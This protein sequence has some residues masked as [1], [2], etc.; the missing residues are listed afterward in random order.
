MLILRILP[1]LEKFSLGE[2]ILPVDLA[3]YLR[4]PTVSQFYIF[5][6]FMERRG[7]TY[8]PVKQLDLVVYLSNP[9]MLRH[10]QNALSWAHLVRL[11]LLLAEGP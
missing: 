1:L 8:T 9:P 5:A 3:P 2:I 4:G 7:K 6:L 11:S 10:P